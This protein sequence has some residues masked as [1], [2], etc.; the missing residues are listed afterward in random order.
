SE[1]AQ[2]QRSGSPGNSPPPLSKSAKTENTARVF[3]KSELF[4]EGRLNSPF[5]PTIF[6]PSKNV[7]SRRLVG[8]FLPRSYV[9]SQTAQPPAGSFSMHFLLTKRAPA[10]ERRAQSEHSP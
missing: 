10:S 9:F 3:A 5:N 2:R 4:S 8:F 7:R 1:T 6:F